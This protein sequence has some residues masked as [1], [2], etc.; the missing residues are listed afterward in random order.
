MKKTIYT[1]QVNGY[2]E[3]ITRLTFPFI[4][5]WANKIGADFHIIKG[6]KF[7]EWPITYEKFQ[8]YELAQ[9]HCNDWNIFVDA[10]TLIHPHTPDW[11]VFMNK[12]TVAHNGSD[13]APIRWRYDKYF[14][15]D[16]RHIAGGNWLAIASDWCIDL[17]KPLDIGPEEAVSN[18]FPIMDEIWG[19]CLADHLVDDYATSRNIARYGLKFKGIK[20]IMDEKGMKDWFFF[21]HLYNIPEDEKVKKIMEVM[22]QW[23]IPAP[24]RQFGE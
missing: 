12:D 5:Y 9:E 17:W 1:L 19:G 16:G 11:T 6:R 24:I 2:S 20:T 3:R 4:R 10:D 22:D 23:K 21:L 14:M 18:I 8:I 7:P 13:F 15:R